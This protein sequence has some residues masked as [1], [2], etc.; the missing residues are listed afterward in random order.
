MRL[1]I[2]FDSGAQ[3]YGHIKTRSV[4][5]GIPCTQL[6]NTK[7]RSLTAFRVVIIGIMDELKQL[8]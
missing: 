1:E 4:S 3:K 8:E 7:T 6:G 2:A 5:E